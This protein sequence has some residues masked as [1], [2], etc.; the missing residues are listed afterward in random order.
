MRA[1][2]ASMNT[3]KGGVIVPIMFPDAPP[4]F[5]QYIGVEPIP[6]RR[7]PPPVAT[8]IGL[9][10]TN[11][12]EPRPPPVISRP[13]KVRRGKGFFD[14]IWKYSQTLW[15][16]IQP[17]ALHISEHPEAYAGIASSITGY[18]RSNKL[19]PSSQKWLDENQNSEI[20]SLK[21]IR[22]PVSKY[23]EGVLSLITKG[24]YDQAKKSLSY[25]RMFHLAL[26]IEL[27]DANGNTTLNK[28]EKLAEPN[29]QKTD[30]SVF[31]NPKT[32][33]ID[34]PLNDK[35]ITAGEFVKNAQA[36]MGTGFYNYDAFSTNCQHFVMGLLD[37]NGLG[38]S[39]IKEFVYQNVEELL[40]QQPQY[41]GDFAKF[42]TN[43]GH[44]KD[45]IFQ[46]YGI[47]PS[48]R[49]CKAN[50]STRSSM[51]IGG[52]RL[53]KINLSESE[54]SPAE[55]ETSA[56]L[57]ECLE[58]WGVDKKKYLQ[59]LRRNAR[60]HGYNPKMIELATDGKHKVQIQTPEGRIVR[61]GRLGY[62]DYILWKALEAQGKSPKGFAEQKKNVFHSS[63]TKIRGNWKKNDYSPNNLAL[64][65]LW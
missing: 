40:R 15:K 16:Y 58:K 2:Y 23:L 1:L 35:Q 4:G 61:F 55:G 47:R 49:G 25:D 36:K 38:S 8:Q 7:E 10:K 60:K 12:E 46:G 28:V 11:I 32:E 37:A 42:I 41:T 3:R 31:A 44:I 30:D 65:L 50:N 24:K 6:H 14:N 59:S 51:M 52:K 54:E 34:V 43:L 45:R 21:A 17:V 64:R 53:V 39:E 27:R 13:S 5:H 48:L 18:F 63:H 56:S 20:V 33:S 29:F 62:G 9:M 19:N 57:E 26:V 22:T